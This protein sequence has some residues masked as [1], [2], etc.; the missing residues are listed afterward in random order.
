MEGED[1]SQDD[2][3]CALLSM[4]TSNLEEERDEPASVS[5][6]GSWKN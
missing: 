5:Y 2:F 4:I 6:D 1:E 3:P